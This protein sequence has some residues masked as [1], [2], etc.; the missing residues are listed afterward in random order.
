MIAFRRFTIIVCLLLATLT[1]FAQKIP[2]KPSPFR[3]VNDYAG[4]MTEPFLSQLEEQLVN[5]YLSTS[6]QIAVVTVD[7][8]GGLPASLYATMLG[9]EWGIGQK[10]I[11]NGI[12][13]LI[14]PKTTDQKG[15]A[16]IATGYGFEA[17]LTDALC[18]R[19]VNEGMIPYFQK[20]D[21]CGGIHAGVACAITVINRGSLSDAL[22]KD[23]STA[24]PE[25]DTE[26]ES[27]VFIKIIKAIFLGA[28]F[29]YFPLWVP[30]FLFNLFWGIVEKD[31]TKFSSFK[32]IISMGCWPFSALGFGNSGGNSSGYRG[33]GGTYSGY[34]G[35]YGYGA[36][37]G[38]F[39]G[40]GG[41]GSW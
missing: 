24:K 35:G 34:G 11:D 33:Y 31:W 40:G 27:N 17:T 28:F 16:F 12:I 19:I 3:F 2:N 9:Q 4:V 41:G 7:S 13:I 30:G 20:E 6:N 18:T 5:L 26:T 22:Q 23:Y 15:E 29:L 38:S 25:S 37:G 21:Y 1:T 32:S 39:G 10:Y 36:G 14:K 8:F